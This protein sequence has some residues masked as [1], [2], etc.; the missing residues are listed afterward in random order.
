MNDIET[1]IFPILNLEDLNFVYDTYRV[2]NLRRE[3][4]EYFQNCDALVHDLSFKLAAPVQRIERG[5][6]LFLIIPSDAVNVPERFSLVRTQ[7]YL[8]KTNSG[9]VLDFLA[10]NPENDAIC[11]RVIQFLLQAPLRNDKRLWQPAAGMPF[12]VKTAAQA[13]R[14]VGRYQGFGRSWRRR[15]RSGCASMY[16]ANTSGRNR[17]RFGSIA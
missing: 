13:D 1:N 2:R 17:C 8:E 12:F 3:Q 15:E 4:D 14:G 10:R 11:L 6:E 9:S 16:A 7:V 5:G